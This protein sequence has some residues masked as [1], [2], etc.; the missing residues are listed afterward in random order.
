MD[1][2]LDALAL[3]RIES[4]VGEVHL[5]CEDCT[6]IRI[7]EIGTDNYVYLYLLND[8]AISAD[9]RFSFIYDPMVHTDLK[10]QADAKLLWDEMKQIVK[11]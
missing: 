2:I 3:C 9:F 6:E 5:D 1:T 8:K 11:F 10:K 4:G 7:D